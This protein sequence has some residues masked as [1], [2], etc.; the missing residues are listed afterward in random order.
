MVECSIC[1]QSL[2][3]NEDK[4]VNTKKALAIA[5]TLCNHYYHSECLEQWIAIRSKCPLC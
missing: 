5:K 4:T 2:L 3:D 1:L